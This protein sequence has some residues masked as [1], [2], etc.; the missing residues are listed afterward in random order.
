LLPAYTRQFLQRRCVEKFEAWR[1]IGRPLLVKTPK[2][3]TLDL[4]V[5]DLLL[6]IPVFILHSSVRT[7]QLFTSLP[8]LLPHW[9]SANSFV[10]HDSLTSNQARQRWI[11]LYALPSSSTYLPP[12]TS[13]PFQEHLSCRQC[14]STLPYAPLSSHN[15][16]CSDR[17]SASTMT[18]Y[19]SLPITIFLGCNKSTAN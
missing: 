17:N 15:I 11:P 5:S 8:C 2:T 6:D 7:T 18:C 13:R 4:D 3:E 12:L 16:V 14:V 9:Q 1:K 19:G 10:F